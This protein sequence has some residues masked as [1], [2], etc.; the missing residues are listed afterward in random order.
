MI[1]L[2]LF[3]FTKPLNTVKAQPVDY[4]FT[5]DCKLY[6]YYTEIISTCHY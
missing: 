4:A 1:L 3:S 6:L 2:E 5:V